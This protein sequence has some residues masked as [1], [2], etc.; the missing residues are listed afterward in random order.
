MRIPN[1][2]K[3]KILSYQYHFFDIYQYH[4][5]DIH[6]NLDFRTFP[7][8]RIPNVSDKNQILKVLS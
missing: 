2:S 3:T 7:S 5:F 6:S 8:M 1:F 4:F